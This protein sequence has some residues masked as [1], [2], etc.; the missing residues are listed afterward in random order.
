MKIL[1]HLKFIKN[2]NLQI[3]T[4]SIEDDWNLILVS[5][6]HTKYFYEINLLLENQDIFGFVNYADHDDVDS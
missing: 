2:L 4:F 6:S 5:E 1:L 3:I